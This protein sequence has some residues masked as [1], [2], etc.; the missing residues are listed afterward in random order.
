M[1]IEK[2]PERRATDT[3]Q[4]TKIWA[5]FSPSIAQNAPMCNAYPKEEAT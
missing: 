3:G 4:A 5:F 1:I 2:C